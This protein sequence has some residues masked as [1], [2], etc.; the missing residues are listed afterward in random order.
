ME[1]RITRNNAQASECVK[2]LFRTVSIGKEC[3]RIVDREHTR[4]LY[5]V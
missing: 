4:F 3:V 5:K 1:S 2:E